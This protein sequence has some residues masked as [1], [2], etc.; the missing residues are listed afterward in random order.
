MGKKK[1][2]IACMKAAARISRKK[3]DREGYDLAN[4]WLEAR[5]FAN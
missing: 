2:A 4:N 3:G 5:G 1:E